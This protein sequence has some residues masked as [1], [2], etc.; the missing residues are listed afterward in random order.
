MPGRP[1]MITTDEDGG[2]INLFVCHQYMQ[3]LNLNE[4]R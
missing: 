1:F 2:V 4:A 3:A